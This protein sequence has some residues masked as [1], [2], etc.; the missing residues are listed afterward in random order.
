MSLEQYRDASRKELWEI[1]QIQADQMAE[2]E[3]VI[4]WLFEC[5]EEVDTYSQRETNSNYIKALDPTND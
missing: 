1:L 2:Q 4:G 3:K 5:C